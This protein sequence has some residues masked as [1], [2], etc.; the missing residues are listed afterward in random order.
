MCS[1]ARSHRGDVPTCDALEHATDVARATRSGPRP[2]TSTHSGCR[3]GGSS[4]STGSSSPSQ[5]AA[6]SRASPTMERRST[7]F[8]VGVTSSTCSWIGRTSASGV[9]G[10]CAP[11]STMIPL[12]ST[13]SSSS[14]SERIIP[15]ET[16]PRSLRSSR[17][18]SAPGS[19]A[20][21]SPTATVAPAPKFQ[22]PHTI[23]RGSPSPTSTWQSWSL[24]AFGCFPAS[25][26][27]P[28]RK[29]PRLPSDVRDAD[30]DHALDLE[31]RDGE[32]PRDL[33]G[34]RAGANV[35]AEPGE[36]CAHGGLELPQQSQVVAPELAQ[37]GD[38]VTEDGHPL[39]PP[40]EREAACN[41]PGRSRRTRRASDR[42]SR[43]RRSRSSRSD[44]RPG[45]RP[46]RRRGRRRTP[47]ST[48]R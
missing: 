45:S 30:V 3:I 36:R 47:R 16:S 28:T 48:A 6:T 13:P 46:R 24:S 5:R 8:I 41:A 26:T 40:A 33:V 4:T 44:G 43:H 7:R 31:R 29:S 10:S 18:A 9:P 17:G 22:A 35:F 20:P 39:E 1:R 42:P 23:C 11:S 34:A 14:R 19:S 25:I 12:W 27:V 32:P 21:G 2:C 15:R 38:A 37:V